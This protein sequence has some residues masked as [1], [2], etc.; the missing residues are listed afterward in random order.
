MNTEYYFLKPLGETD[1]I[2]YAVPKEKLE[3]LMYADTYDSKGHFIGNDMGVVEK[4]QG[5]NYWDGNKHATIIVGADHEELINYE[6]LKDKNLIAELNKALDCKECQGNDLGIHTYKGNGFKITRSYTQTWE[7][8]KI[9]K[10][11]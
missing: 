5:F 10:Y 7:S 2:Y 6:M 8:W 11:K 4:V 9:E 1:E 3:T